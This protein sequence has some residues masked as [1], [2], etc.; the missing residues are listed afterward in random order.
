MVVLPSCKG[1]FLFTR[2]GT[3]NLPDLHGS[4][5][6][7]G[8]NDVNGIG[9]KDVGGLPNITGGFRWSNGQDSWGAFL[10]GTLSGSYGQGTWHGDWHGVDFD[11]SRSSNI[12]NS[13][14]TEVQ[15]KRI[16]MYYVIK[17]I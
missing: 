9:Y 12:Y 8:T 11:A 15:P 6:I 2:K 17:Y 5:T 7:T 1:G 13:N 4:R 14:N 10:T 3:F 16:M